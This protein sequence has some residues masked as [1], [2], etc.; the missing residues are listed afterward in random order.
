MSHDGK[1]VR[2]NPEM[3]EERVAKSLNLLGFGPDIELS[4]PA[5]QGGV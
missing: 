3:T 4:P 5:K 2:M 1:Q